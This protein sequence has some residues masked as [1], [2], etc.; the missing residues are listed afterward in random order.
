MHKFIPYGTQNI[1]EDDIQAVV[2]VLKSDFISTG[3]MVMEFEKNF[4]DKVNSKYAVAVSSGTAALHCACIAAGISEGDEVLTSPLTFVATANAVLYQKAKPVFVDINPYT[5][6]MD[7][8]KIEELIT[9]KTKAIIPVHFAGLPCN[10][11]K[12]MEISRKYK[13]VVIEDAAHALGSV[14][15]NK[16]I[17]SIGDMT[18]F[19]FHPVKHITTG[20]GGMVT[21]ND[22]VLYRTLVMSR[23]HGITRDKSLYVNYCDNPWYYEQ[24][25]LGFNYRL[26]DFQCALGCTQLKK[27]DFSIRRR[28]AIANSYIEHLSAIREVE[29]PHTLTDSQVSWHIFAIRIVDESLDRRDV[30]NYLRTENIG[31]NVHY[32]PVYL[33]PYYAKLGYQRG[34]CP[35]AESVYEQ[36]ITLPIHPKMTDDDVNYVIKSVKEAVK[37]QR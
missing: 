14:Y 15:E 1:D 4:A 37:N 20:E 19:S 8:D 23:N 27:L 2:N 29:L 32:I 6:N 10:M 35:N 34:L 21:T 5:Y 7:V 31:V 30:F 18:A 28:T 12:I 16:R 9:E 24:Q 17:G 22:E 25:E 36:L 3:P 13:L 26:T 33:H 11:D